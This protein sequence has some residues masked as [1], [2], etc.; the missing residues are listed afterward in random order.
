MDDA[1]LG[2][3]GEPLE[4]ILDE[5][6]RLLLRQEP[7]LL[8]EHV[9]VAPVAHLR[10]DE[11]LPLVVEDVVAFQHVRVADLHQH[12]QLRPVQLLQLRGF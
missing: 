1:I 11:A 2:E 9:Q 7:L 4:D 12:L 3:I 6:S 10:D 8:D 5:V